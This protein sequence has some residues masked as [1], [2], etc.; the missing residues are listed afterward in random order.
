L[1]LGFLFLLFLDNL[2]IFLNFIGD[3]IK[4]VPQYWCFLIQ[5]LAFKF[6][7]I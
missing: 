6:L 1:L 5:F 7:I 4:I 3:Y 2:N